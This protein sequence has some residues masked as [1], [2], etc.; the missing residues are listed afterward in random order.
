MA[1][2][3]IKNYKQHLL[4]EKSEELPKDNAKLDDGFNEFIAIKHDPTAKVTIRKKNKSGKW[5][6]S[7]SIVE[8]LHESNA[9]DAGHKLAKLIQT[10]NTTEIQEQYQ[11][12]NF[13]LDNFR[14]YA[15]G[16][17]G[18]VKSLEVGIFS[19]E[20]EDEAALHLLLQNTRRY[21]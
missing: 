18:S 9:T 12:R 19:S 10:K 11:V 1:N 16:G 21:L 4:D 17:T 8:A 20:A 15:I 5:S 2:I 14:T 6:K 7:Q 3:D 13:S